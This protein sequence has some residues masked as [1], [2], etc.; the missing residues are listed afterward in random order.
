MLTANKFP[1]NPYYNE[2]NFCSIFSRYVEYR[3][4]E[5]EKRQVVCK[6]CGKEYILLGR[7][8]YKYCLYSDY[9]SVCGKV[10]NKAMDFIEKT[11]NCN[12]QEKANTA[13]DIEDMKQEYKVI[14]K[15]KSCNHW[16]SAI[17]DSANKL[18]ELR[19]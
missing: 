5:G 16:I 3:I 18:R 9:C 2:G 17:V 14:I 7:K 19:F 12:W 8:G 10:A 15:G 11:C 1:H 6:N 4:N 13:Y